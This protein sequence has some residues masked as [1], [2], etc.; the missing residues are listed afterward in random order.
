MSSLPHTFALRP[1]FCVNK[2]SSEVMA[3][4]GNHF[5][6]LTLKNISTFFTSYKSCSLESSEGRMDTGM[7]PSDSTSMDGENRET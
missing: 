7:S 3:A 4:P 1:F 5:E 2:T 6:I